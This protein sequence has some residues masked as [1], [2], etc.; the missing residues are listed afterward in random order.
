MFDK[1]LRLQAKTGELISSSIFRGDSADE[2]SKCIA[3]CTKSLVS[4]PLREVLEN[5]KATDLKMLKA[6]RAVLLHFESIELKNSPTGKRD[7]KYVENFLVSRAF[8]SNMNFVSNSKSRKS[9]AAVGCDQNTS[10]K[11]NVA[12]GN[13]SASRDEDDQIINCT[14]KVQTSP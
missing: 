7:E 5:S 8:M 13:S 11:C 1:I 2:A 9:D 12:S 10:F 14:K 4:M 6:R 3:L